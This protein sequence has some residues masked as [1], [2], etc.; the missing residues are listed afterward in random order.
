MNAGRIK[1]FNKHELLLEDE[2]YRGRMV[3]RKVVNRWE[4]KYRESGFH[5]GYIHIRPATTDRF[6][7][8][9]GRN[10][11]SDRYD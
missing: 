2:Y 3:R 9:D 7:K 6:R 10:Y 8:K 5:E 1:Y 11:Y 4:K